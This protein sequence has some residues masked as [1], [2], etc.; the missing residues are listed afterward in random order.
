ML[1]L[2]ICKDN[3]LDKI[4]NQINKLKETE[5]LKLLKELLNESLEDLENIVDD[6][7]VT[8]KFRMETVYQEN[9]FSMSSTQSSIL[10]AK[11]KA[12][13]FLDRLRNEIENNEQEEKRVTNNEFSDEMALVI[14]RK[15]LN[16]FYYHIEAMYE[17]KVH[18]KGTILRENLDKI[19]IGNE[20]DVQRILYSI[21]KPIFPEARLEVN[22]DT[23]YGTIRYDIIIE[24]YQIVIETKCTRDN[25]SE[26]KLTEELGSDA[27]HYK[28]K[29]IFFFIY[30]KEKIVA[31]KVAFIKAYSK[32][33]NDK[34][35]ETVVIQPITL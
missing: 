32:S 26:K 1:S 16:N 4:N 20:Y 6:E 8:A 34:K 29:N 28:Y 27:F 12:I 11:K 24:K 9:S 21:I 7:K 33:Y 19:K 3:A 13:Y 31:N 18:R 2:K 14:I 10:N 15:I 30:D 5:D 17:D 22:N 25:M 23:G 35:I